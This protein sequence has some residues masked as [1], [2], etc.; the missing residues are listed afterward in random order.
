MNK[1]GGFGFSIVLAIII[2][3]CGDSKNKEIVKDPLARMH[4]SLVRLIDTNEAKI[5]SSKNSGALDMQ[6]ASRAVNTYQLFVN[7]FPADS[8]AALYLFKTA[9]IYE[10]ALQQ[11]NAA[12]SCLEKITQD[13]PSFKKLPTVYLQ[14]GVI[15]DDNLNDEVKAKMYYETFLKRFPNSKMASQVQILISDLGKSNNDLC[16]EFDKK[17]LPAGQA[18]KK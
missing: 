1:K 5:N 14:L 13:Y 8:N 10:G 11:Y 7:K 2:S 3:A 18:G 4:D 9:A 16:K 15:Y 6:L 17:N 12:V